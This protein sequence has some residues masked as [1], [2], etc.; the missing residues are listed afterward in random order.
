[1]SFRPDA[2]HARRALSGR[3]IQRF[4]RRRRSPF[5][6]A[7]QRVAALAILLVPPSCQPAVTPPDSGSAALQLVASS[8]PATVKTLVVVVTAA[9]IPAPKVFNIAVSGGTAS[10]TITVPVGPARTVT[11]RAYDAGG[12][13][14]HRGATSVNVQAGGNPTVSISLDALQGQQVIEVR[15]ESL[16]I[17]ITPATLTVRVDQTVKVQAAVRTLAGDPVTVA[18]GDVRWA[19]LQP[20]V[21]TVGTAG[22]VLG[23]STGSATIVAVYAGVAGTA[24]V[25]VE[26]AATARLTPHDATRQATVSNTKGSAAK[27]FATIPSTPRYHRYAGFQT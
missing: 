3:A 1:V 25:K 12:I 4:G 13:E 22:D 14:S 23:V 10:G 7:R 6:G 26:P 2:A 5:G 17:T 15:V 27:L 8:V 16:V 18:P 11:I 19:T 9:D 24:A 20:N 21:A